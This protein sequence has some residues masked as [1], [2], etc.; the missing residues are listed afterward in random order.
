FKP[1]AHLYKTQVYALGR[2]LN[3]PAKILQSVPTTGTYSL[4]QTQEEFYFTLPYDKMDLCLFGRN[5]AI[6]PERVAS[7]AGLTAGDVERAYRIID[8][9]RKAA[10]YLHMPPLLVEYADR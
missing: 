6:P 1:I 8:A 7:A 4:P 9:K 5:H 3:V 10:R 2:Y